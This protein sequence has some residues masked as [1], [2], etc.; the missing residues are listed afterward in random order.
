MSGT[1][2]ATSVFLR[3]RMARLAI[4]A[5]L[6]ALGL[7]L[8]GCASQ[9]APAAASTPPG[10]PYLLSGTCD[11]KAVEYAVGRPAT[12]ALQDEVIVKSHAKFIRVIQPGEAVAQQFSSQRLNLQVNGAQAVTAVSCG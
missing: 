7:G 8:A 6:A 1:T 11:A 5:A 12:Q 4:G 3:P 10:Q 2:T 9:G